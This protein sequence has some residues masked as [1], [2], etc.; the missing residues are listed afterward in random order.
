MMHTFDKANE[1]AP[2]SHHTQYFEMMGDHAIYHNGWIA[3]TKVVRPP[4][5]VFGRADVNPASLPWEL[6]DLRRDWTQYDDVKDK[7]PGKLKELQ[8]LFWAEAAKYQVLPLDASV[9]TR[10][11]IP[12]PSLTAGRNADPHENFRTVAVSL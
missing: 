10:L 1:N 4:W 5:V 8:N 9:A 12:K 2:S 6:Y 7:Y 11:I 3:S